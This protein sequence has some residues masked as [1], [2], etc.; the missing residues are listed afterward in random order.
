MQKI[1]VKPRVLIPVL[2]LAAA[3]ALVLLFTLRGN[4]DEPK[5]EFADYAW[6]SV[7]ND[8]LESDITALRF[9]FTIG[10]LNY[11]RVG[12]V[13]SKTNANPTEGV[14]G[15]HVSEATKVYSSVSADGKQYTADAD[16]YWVALKVTGIPNADFDQ[17][18]YARPFVD[19]GEGIRYGTT[20]ALSVE[21][22]FAIPELQTQIA[23]FG[24]SDFGTGSIRADLGGS[25]AVPSQHPTQGQHPRVL[26]TSASID[27]LN[28]A[29]ASATDEAKSIYNAALASSPDGVIADDEFDKETDQSL[30]ATIQLLALDYRMTG[31]PYSGYRAIYAI[32]NVLKTLTDSWTGHDDTAHRYYGYAMYIT[33]CVYDWCYDL[34]TPTD[35]DQIVLGVQE[36][37]CKVGMT[38]QY[39]VGFPPT[40]ADAVSGHGTAFQILR[41]YLAFAIAIYD[42]YPGWW[43]MIAGRFY[44]EYVPVR[45]TFYEAGLNPQGVSLYLSSK[46]FADLYSAWL[47]KAATGVFPYESETNMKQ[48]A[49]TIFSYELRVNNGGLYGFASG[50]DHPPYG[51]FLDYGQ[52]ALISSYLFNDSTMRAQ[53]EYDYNHASPSVTSR[54]MGSSYTNFSGSLTETTTVAEYL[55]C[56]S[57]GLEPAADR[58]EGMDLILYNGGWLGQII[59]RNTWERSQAAVLMKIGQRTVANHDHYDAGSFQIFYKAMLAGDSGVYDVYGSDHHKYY[60]QATI[61][62]NSLLIY[63]P[64]HSAT[65]GGYYSGGQERLNDANLSN[66]Q[67]ET[68]KTG[69]VTGVSYGYADQ[70]KTT[71][72][73][74]YLAGDIAAAYP[75]STVS[76]VT[77]RMLVVYDT[78]DTTVPMFFFV[79]DN[80]TSDSGSYKKTFLLHTRYEPEIPDGYDENDKIWEVYNGGA[81]LRI[82][83]VIGNGVSITPVGGVVKT[84]DKYNCANSENYS[85][86]GSQLCP[87][88]LYNDNYWGRLEI[89]PATGNTTDQLLNAMYVCDTE[90]AVDLVATAIDTNVVKGAAIGNTV[91]VFV[92][93]AT[94]RTTEFSFTASGSGTK[95][96]YVSGV[97]EGDWTVCVGGEP[98]N[99]ATATEEGG[100]ITFSAPA[101]SEITLRPGAPNVTVE[102]GLPE[103][104]WDEFSFSNVVNP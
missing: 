65:D 13:L 27:G 19:D 8:T 51:A 7:S 44:A 98:I 17:P 14:D 74:A 12:F 41:D 9:L 70:A 54:T 57:S 103:N 86:N 97:A 80:I 28:A 66:W 1:I 61:A 84:D 42:E 15:C 83:N 62:H 99:V 59:A 73:Y 55:I 100:F 82:Q 48:V 31:N 78:D 38:V 18:I 11:T 2:I 81:T 95:N 22:A 93:S 6:Q 45:N 30:L 29:L 3:L 89:S 36:K 10:N 79:F 85:V 47:V 104:G 63:N 52:I 32:K 46:T 39:A 69:D 26:F 87:P 5:G 90:K 101:G 72:T 56:S 23:A 88:H 92:T 53:V 60:H 49:R 71:P 58:H 75:S 94:R 34:L 16:R 64:S 91:A 68:Y 76:E 77:R 21:G 20:H 67:S 40:G 50:D 33:A 102:N 35:K 96:Y 4:A 43:N 24:G 25:Y 37:I